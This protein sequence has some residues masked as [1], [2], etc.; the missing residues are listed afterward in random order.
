MGG[1]VSA[2][3]SV[4]V[5]ST[6]GAAAKYDGAL[7]EVELGSGERMLMI[8]TDTGASWHSVDQQSHYL[9][10][11]NGQDMGVNNT[12]YQSKAVG[13]FGIHC[14][15]PWKEKDTAGLMPQMSIRASLDHIAGRVT[16]IGLQTQGCDDAAV[17]GTAKGPSFF[18]VATT[19]PTGTWGTM[20]TTAHAWYDW[21]EPDTTAR[22]SFHLTAWAASSDVSTAGPNVR[23]I[24]AQVR[25]VDI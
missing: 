17:P 19:H 5:V 7:C 10:V 25:W 3:K 12:Y 6:I 8:Y 24:F 2:Y 16:T 11:V 18:S 4:Q 21:I 20:T 13:G 22:D 1:L 15:I 23:G 9:G 14:S